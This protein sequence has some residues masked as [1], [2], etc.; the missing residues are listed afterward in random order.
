MAK[1][2]FVALVL[3]V[4]C[5]VVLSGCISPAVDNQLAAV[6]EQKARQEG[7]IA[8]RLEAEAGQAWAV[9]TERQARAVA[10]SSLW[11][12][13]AR[14]WPSL[15]AVVLVAVAV[16][17]GGASAAWA[18]WAWVRSSVQHLGGGVYWVERRGVVALLD[19]SRMVG[20]V[21]QLDAGQVRHVLA[22]GDELS[23]DIARAA[24]VAR[25]VERVGGN[26]SRAE[27]AG[28]LAETVAGAFQSLAAGGGAASA[29]TKRV[30]ESGPS[31]RFIKMHSPEQ[32]A[33][34]RAANEAAE[35]DEFLSEGQS[36]GYG[37]RAWAGYTFR[38]TGR[39]CSQ[40]RWAIL[41]GWLREA[42]LLDGS[43]L[44]CDLAEARARLGLVGSVGMVDGVG[45]QGQALAE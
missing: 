6:V 15:V 29:G 22:V 36:R 31:L 20:G 44:V 25:A 7:A 11:A 35:L 30:L 2:W 45:H 19:T 5:V 13:W 21:V 26:E 32:K 40:T 24:L 33:A 27:L 12:E 42:E 3:V 17:I 37:R 14:R 28:R 41:A 16:V 39:A 1:A 43:A 8:E 4:V 23:A 34:S 9:T 10:L 38:C 18:R